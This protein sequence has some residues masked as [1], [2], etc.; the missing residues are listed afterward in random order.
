MACSLHLV[1]R[2]RVESV[3]LA[4]RTVSDR[5]NAGTEA[6]F[7]SPPHRA[8]R[9]VPWTVG[10]ADD[11]SREAGCGPA[12]SIRRQALGGRSRAGRDTANPIPRI[13]EA[14]GLGP[15]SGAGWCPGT[16]SN[17][18]HCD[19]QSHALPT[20]LPGRRPRRCRPRTPRGI[21]KAARPV[22]PC[23]D[24]GVTERPEKSSGVWIRLAGR[25]IGVELLGYGV[26][27]VQPAPQ[28]DVSAA[29]R[30]ERPEFRRLGP[31]ADRT[32]GTHRAAHARPP[33]PARIGYPSPSSRLIVS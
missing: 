33:H 10:T 7:H 4:P 18:R 26:T 29:L 22:Q 27:L 28:V 8:A 20:E 21:V 31:S 32:G 5:S 6:V 13:G 25:L 2:A 24:T 30:A 3:M 14:L 12:G 23:R 17:R 9:A 16:E 11:L 1:R 15:L 19:F